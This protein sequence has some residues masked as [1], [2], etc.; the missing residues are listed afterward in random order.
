MMSKCTVSNQQKRIRKRRQAK[1]RE[2]RGPE[3]VHAETFGGCRGKYKERK[4]GRKKEKRET[5]DGNLIQWKLIAGAVGIPGA[6][7][8][9]YRSSRDK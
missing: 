2:W 9:A 3:A 6:R 4:K 7:F 1:R 5:T 8:L